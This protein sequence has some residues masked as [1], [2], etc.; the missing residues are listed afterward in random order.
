MAGVFDSLT[1]L[2]SRSQDLA[3]VV[4]DLL[5]VVETNEKHI[6]VSNNRGTPKWMVYKGKHY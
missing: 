2:E 1:P 3:T 5:E 6:G 4:L